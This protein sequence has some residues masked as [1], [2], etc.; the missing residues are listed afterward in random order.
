MIKGKKTVIILLGC[1]LF[2]P[3]P[4]ARADM[5]VAQ[6]YAVKA[7]FLYNFAKFVD[8]PDDVYQDGETFNICV[9]GENPFGS[10][11][12]ALQGKKVKGRSL[13]VHVTP[14]LTTVQTCHILF[15]SQSEQDR[16]EAI[17]KGV[18]ARGV[19]LVSDVE[20][21]ARRGG[22]IQLY[23]EQRK[24]RFTVNLDATKNAELKISSK[25]LR[26]A[27]IVETKQE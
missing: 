14:D 20:Q 22:M 17:M 12:A 26:L 19:L 23:M 15:V 5:P 25:L 4:L 7:A 6:E 11:L 13:K 21:F 10:S 27:Q 8:W 18:S 16:L 1:L 2:F 9:V 3:Y 24:V